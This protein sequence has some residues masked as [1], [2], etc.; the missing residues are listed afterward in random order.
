MSNPK[1]DFIGLMTEINRA[2]GLDELSSRLIGMLF[3]E[4]EEV[5][6]DDLSKRTGYSLSAVS[7]SMKLLEGTGMIKRIKKPGSKK[8]YFYMEKDLISLFSSAL[9]RMEVSI[10]SLKE[11]VPPII[12][13]YRKKKDTQSKK[14]MK[15][16][17]NYHSQLLKMEKVMKK[18]L[19]ALME[20]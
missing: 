9:K 8:V 6:M 7:T 15:I 18:H 1:E 10:A 14:E 3:I 5:S 20:V 17:E 4:P 11:K 16:V 12:A 13:E 2:K 19:E